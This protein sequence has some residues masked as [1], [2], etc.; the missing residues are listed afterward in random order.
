MPSGSL[1]NQGRQRDPNLALR[2]RLLLRAPSPL[3]FL[4]RLLVDEYDSLFEGDGIRI[5]LLTD[6]RV[7][8][9][10]DNRIGWRSTD[11]IQK[12]CERFE[13]HPW[14]TYCK[15]KWI[16][17]RQLATL[18]KPFKI[19]SKTERSLG[20]KRGY[21]SEVFKDSFK[22]YL[23]PHT[24]ST[25]AP[26]NLSATSATSCKNKDIGQD[27]SAT[28]GVRVTDGKALKPAPALAVADVAHRKGG[29]E[30]EHIHNDDVG[31][32]EGTWEF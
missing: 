24:S 4:R 21:M 26:P 10:E 29:M 27:L 8:F 15:G 32:T 12:L 19:K 9:Q 13:D 1:P 25:S 18:L 14:P 30:E 16:T 20:S 2:L 22:R 31:A 28:T 5:Q 6:L 23:P 11:L 17:P 3:P 7:I